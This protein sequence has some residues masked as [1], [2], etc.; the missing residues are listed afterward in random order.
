[1]NLD[2]R[3][4]L[5]LLFDKYNGFLT[6]GQKQTLHLYLVEDL[7]LAE[8]ADILVTTRQSVFDSIK[9]SKIKLNKIKERMG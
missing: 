7:T 8:I 1:M 3:E 9:K 2:N 4:D 5:I 6:Q